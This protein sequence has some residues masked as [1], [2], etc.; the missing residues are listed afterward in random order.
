MRQNTRRDHETRIADA[1]RFIV[2]HLGESIDLG[3]LAD[4]AYMSRFH[5]HRVFQGLLGE[6]AADLVRRLRLERAAVQL[7]ATQTPITDLAFESGYATHEAFIKSFRTAFGCTPSE[8][9]KHVRYEGSLPTPNGLHIKSPQVYRFVPLQGEPKVNIEV[10]EFPTRK[11]V[12]MAH[13]GPYYMIGQ[14]FDKLG[15][16]MQA[17]PN[18]YGQGIGLYY[19]DPSS[20]PPD[21]LRSDAG[22]F[23]PDNFSTEDSAVHIVDVEGGAY[24]VTEYRG[25]YDG[26]SGVWNEF[27]RAE[28]P[29]GYTHRN[30][31]PFEVYITM[32]N[33][34]GGA[35]AVTEL[36]LPI[37]N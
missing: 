30:G 29:E 23:V 31:P 6:T 35:D 16:W 2:E 10:H 18:P 19:D 4:R 11:A 24:A 21:Q 20:T 28:L 7:R 15:A 9:R 1:I 3:A 22:M 36:Y 13:S 12:C 17:N 5:F 25:S 8:M 32:G 34:P 14:T 37:T 33:Q 27:S 26:L